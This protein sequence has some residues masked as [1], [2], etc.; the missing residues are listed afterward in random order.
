MAGGEQAL[1]DAQ[2]LFLLPVITAQKIAKF[3]ACHFALKFGEAQQGGQEFVLIKQHVFVERHVSYADGTLVAE[4]SIIAENGH[5]KHG[6]AVR[7]EAAMAVVITDGVGSAE[8]GNP[9]GFEQRNQPGL[10]LARDSDRTGD[11]KRKRAA[12]ADGAIE[13]GI[14]SAKICA[15]KCG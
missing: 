7:V 9:A 13:D 2:R 15:A 5:F 1:F 11:G 12:H 10:M 14:N 3:G 4:C 8:V 6:V